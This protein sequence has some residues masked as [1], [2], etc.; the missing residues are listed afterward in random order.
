LKAPIKK[1]DHVADLIARTGDGPPQVMPL[2]A[3]SDVGRPASSGGSATARIGC[4]ADRD[5]Q[6]GP[7]HQP[8]RRGGRRQIDPIARVGGGFARAR[9]RGG[10]TREPG[11]SPGAEAIRTLLLE[12]A[13][14]RWTAEAEALLFAAARRS[15]RATIRPALARG[16]WVICDRFST[17]RSPI[18]AADGAWAMRRS[19][20]LHGIGSGACC[21][22]GPCCCRFAR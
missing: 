7:L 5:A 22:T 2:V 8:R 19:G 15:C 10:R 16:A 1:G 17:A 4:S 11:G 12:G 9:D 6:A 20:R 3:A 14:D 21:P 13:G 18:R